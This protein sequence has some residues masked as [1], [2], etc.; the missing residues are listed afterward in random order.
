M[1]YLNSTKN[2]LVPVNFN[3]QIFEFGNKAVLNMVAVDI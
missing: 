1:I 3:K 2:I